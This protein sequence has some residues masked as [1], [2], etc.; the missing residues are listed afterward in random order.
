MAQQLE[1]VEDGTD[2][3]ALGLV[4]EA[5]GEVWQLGQ[6]H[7]LNDAAGGGRG[8]PEIREGF[9][10]PGQGGEATGLD[11]PLEGGTIGD[12]GFGPDLGGGGALGEHLEGAAFGGDEPFTTFAGHSDSP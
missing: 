3:T 12:G 10:G 1:E 6:D 9:R 11:L 4:E 5:A 8:R 7:V 2:V